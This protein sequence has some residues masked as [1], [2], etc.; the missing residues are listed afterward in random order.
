MTKSFAFVLVCVTAIGAAVYS[1]CA[2]QKD[3]RKLVWSDEYDV[4]ADDLVE[5][6]PK[7]DFAPGVVWAPPAQRKTNDHILKCAS[8][9]NNAVIRILRAQNVRIVGEPGFDKHLLRRRFHGG[10]V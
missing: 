6:V 1:A 8:R 9:W 7:C 5:P 4:L 2:A 10:S 3:G